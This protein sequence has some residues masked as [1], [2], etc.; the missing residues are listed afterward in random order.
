MAFAI[1]RADK[2]LFLI[3]D[4]KEQILFFE[5]VH[6]NVCTGGP[7]IV[8]FYVPEKSGVMQNS[9]MHARHSK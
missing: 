4:W 9:T 7:C 3:F 8:P 6:S 5:I 1:S 2:F